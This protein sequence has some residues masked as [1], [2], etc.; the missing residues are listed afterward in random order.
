MD[1]EMDEI[2]MIHTRI[3]LLR[4]HDTRPKSQ[5]KK[6]KGMFNIFLLLVPLCLCVLELFPLNRRRWFRTNIIHDTIDAFDF[7]DDAVG[8]LT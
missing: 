7:I 4:T 2:G 5:V 1:V 8:Y 6:M 3:K